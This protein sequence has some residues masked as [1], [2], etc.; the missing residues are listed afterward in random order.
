LTAGPYRFSAE[1]RIENIR[2]FEAAAT[3]Q[4][5]E[6]RGRAPDAPAGLSSAGGVGILR[7][8]TI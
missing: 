1:A 3:L 2:I 5:Q 7:C 6:W 8:E 4:R